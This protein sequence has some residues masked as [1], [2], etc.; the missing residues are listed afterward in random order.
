[1]SD[2]ILQQRMTEWAVEELRQ[3]MS[4]MVYSMINRLNALSLKR[5]NFED[6]CGCNEIL[7]AQGFQNELTE[8]K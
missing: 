3:G 7:C 5:I 8:T 4:Y 1:M 6:F 2:L